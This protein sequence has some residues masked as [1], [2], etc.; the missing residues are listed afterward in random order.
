MNIKTDNVCSMAKTA[1]T[2][3]VY[4]STEHLVIPVY[5]DFLLLLW[6]NAL[7]LL[8]QLNRHHPNYM[9]TSH[10]NPAAILLSKRIIKYNLTM[11]Q[12][13]INN[14]KGLPN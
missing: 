13:Y 4:S 12:G 9:T 1:F 11:W 10:K 5:E 14:R 7:I 6:A 3:Y 2:K 8:L